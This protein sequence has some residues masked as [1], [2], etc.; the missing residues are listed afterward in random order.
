MRI[1]E[2]FVLHEIAGQAVVTPTG[3][4]SETFHG[5]VKLN[6][7]AADIWRFLE[8]GLSD[9]EIVTRMTEKY[10]VDEDTAAADLREILD[11]MEKAG[12]T[13]S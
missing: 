9:G 4:A 10:G 12:F 2:G 7:T 8:E 11:K 13:E 6:A 3:K 5:M 1:K